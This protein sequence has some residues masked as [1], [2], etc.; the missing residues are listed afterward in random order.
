MIQPND[1]QAIYDLAVLDTPT[2]PAT[3]VAVY[4]ELVTENPNGAHSLFNLGLLLEKMGD[5]TE[6]TADVAK[7]V[8]IGPNLG[9]RLAR[10]SASTTIR[11]ATVSTTRPTTATTTPS[12]STTTT[13]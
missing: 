11:P 7:A 8:A 2:Q 4:R 6:G 10:S 13:H 5:E 1:T 3:S 12:S 9:S